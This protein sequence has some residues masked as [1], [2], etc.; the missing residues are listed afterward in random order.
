MLV[1]IRGGSVQVDRIQEQVRRTRH[2]R[3]EQPGE[4]VRAQIVDPI[5]QDED[6]DRHLDDLRGVAMHERDA[7]SVEK[8]SRPHD[9]WIDV[10]AEPSRRVNVGQQLTEPGTNLDDRSGRQ[11]IDDVDDEPFVGPARVGSQSVPWVE[12]EVPLQNSQPEQVKPAA[13]QA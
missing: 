2:Q 6:V 4:L 9:S 5:D 8:P 3:L 12:L 13:N 10:V 1:A 11:S 7:T